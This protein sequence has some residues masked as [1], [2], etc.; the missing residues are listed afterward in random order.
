MCPAAVG[1][2]VLTAEA[3]PGVDRRG[4]AP[5]DRWA[6]GTAA[7]VGTLS[8]AGLV[9]TTGDLAS[10]PGSTLPV[11]WSLLLPLDP[12]TRATAAG[13]VEITAVALLVVSWWA[14]LLR[15]HHMSG[16][17]AL[18]I[19]GL[20]SLPLAIGLPLLSHDAYSYLAQGRLSVLGM[21]PYRDSPGRLGGGVWLQGV[22]PVWRGARS[23]YGP[24]VVLSERLAALTGNPI[25]AL[26]FLHVIA[27][28]CLAAIAFVVVRLT[29]PEKL[30]TVLLLTVVNPLVLLQLL[31][32]AHWETLLAGLLALS[33][34]AWRRGRFG[35]AI[36]LASTAAAV[37]MPAMFAVVVLALLWVLSSEG[38]GRWRRAVAAA[39]ATVAPWLVLYAVVPD[40][41]GFRR[42][43]LTPLSGRTLY[44]PTTLLAQI[45]AS[46]LRGFGVVVDF[47]A[48]LSI[49]RVGGMLA[50][51]T[52]CLFLLVTVRSRQPAKTIGLGLLAVAILGPVVYPWYLTW[53]LLPLALVSWRPN[54][55]ARLSTVAVFTALPG[56]SAL[57]GALIHFRPE[58]V[59]GMVAVAA[60]VIA[61]SL[62]MASLEPSSAT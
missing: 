3:V 41:L 20:W 62:R 24:L 45:T 12:L 52:A 32:A 60:A 46:V 26:V 4:S 50:A 23:P 15:R 28:L 27:L 17:L 5:H 51:V 38:L 29:A 39:V 21:D 1:S 54:A 56:C 42:A 57:G 18:A 10:I 35:L 9:A 11:S 16:K 8:A 19:G 44:A 22:D 13:G 58:P 14:L 59:V 55:I 31:A 47:D 61:Y 30:T 43:L 37:K 33:L 7:V 48:V 49:W 25:T 34:Y 6:I 36:A 40:A 2:A 53:G